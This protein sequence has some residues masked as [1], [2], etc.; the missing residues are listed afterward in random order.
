MKAN[1][2]VEEMQDSSSGGNA[3]GLHR[4]DGP[5][6]DEAKDDDILYQGIQQ[7]NRT[8]KATGASLQLGFDGSEDP[9]AIFRDFEAGRDPFQTL[10][11]SNDDDNQMKEEVFTFETQRP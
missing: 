10:Y 5:H 7:P 2:I 1:L 8:G 6:H 9:E 11:D 3:F 4:E